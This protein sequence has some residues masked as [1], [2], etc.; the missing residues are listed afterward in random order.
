MFQG[1]LRDLLI[2]SPIVRTIAFKLYAIIP[3]INPIISLIVI[4]SYRKAIMGLFVRVWSRI[5]ISQV[6]PSAPTSNNLILL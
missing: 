4:S 1:S 3:V 6:S 5:Y 2:K